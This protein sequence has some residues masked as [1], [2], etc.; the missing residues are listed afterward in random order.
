MTRM[1]VGDTGETWSVD[2]VD[3]I[4]NE[5]QRQEFTIMTSGFRSA[6]SNFEM[7]DST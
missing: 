2:I 5:W 6:D 4:Y 1:S 3:Q 7:T